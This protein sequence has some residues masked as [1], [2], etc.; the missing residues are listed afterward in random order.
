MKKIVILNEAKRSEESQLRTFDLAKHLQT[1]R[2]TQSDE[3][4]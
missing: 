2:C 1:L 4:V 3:G